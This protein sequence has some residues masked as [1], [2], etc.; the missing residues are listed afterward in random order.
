VEEQS[1]N[2][3]ATAAAGTAFITLPE[4]VAVATGSTARASGT[5]S[6]LT[7]CLC[8]LEIPMFVKEASNAV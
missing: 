6:I 4:V 7:A 5:T 8:V 3:A 1:E 2:N